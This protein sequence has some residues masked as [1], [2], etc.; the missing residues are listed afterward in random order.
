MWLGNCTDFARIDRLT[1][2]AAEELRCTAEHVKARCNGGKDNASNIVAACLACNRGRHDG[3]A[4]E[5]PDADA[6]KAE[7]KRSAAT[8]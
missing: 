5:A 4:N 8:R 2:H 1:L 6:Y 3:R 7:V